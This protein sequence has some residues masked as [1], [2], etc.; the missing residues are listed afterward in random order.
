[1]SMTYALQNIA[2]VG[3]PIGASL[4]YNS[5]VMVYIIDE[6][7]KLDD[8][9]LVNCQKLLSD[10]RIAVCK[11]IRPSLGK[12]ASVVVYLLLRIALYENYGIDEAI[13]FVHEEKGKPILKDYSH[14]HFSLSH[15]H[16]IAAC[17]VSDCPVGIDVQQIG[18]ISDKV[19][20]RVLTDGEYE[21]FC[22]SQAPEDYFCKVWTV[23]ESYLKQL[24]VGITAGFKT[25]SS[26]NILDKMVFKNNNYYCCVCG[27]EAHNMQVTRIG[28]EQF[29]ELYNGLKS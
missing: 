19:A 17:A 1:M 24:G 7:E 4:C 27:N 28:R 26:E 22:K 25:I 15:S 5:L 16:N 8:D 2:P 23:K 20:K 9:F 12:K 3:I 18:S 10:E 11:R 6:V 29:D 14:I 13:E 21:V